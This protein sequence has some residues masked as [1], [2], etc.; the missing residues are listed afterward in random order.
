MSIAPPRIPESPGDP[1]ATCQL[2]G[3]RV[4]PGC[5]LQRDGDRLGLGHQGR[6]VEQVKGLN[7]TAG[8]DVLGL[9]REP[10]VEVGNVLKMSH[11]AEHTDDICLTPRLP[12][13]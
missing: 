3:S 9:E 7:L 5:R 6:P 12:R 8:K 11:Q 1:P 4:T 10:L 13:G 2:R